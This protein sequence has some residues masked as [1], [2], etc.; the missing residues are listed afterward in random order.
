MS[1]L[2]KY[3][4]K[5]SYVSSLRS[6]KICSW[7]CKGFSTQPGV[8]NSALVDLSI[9]FFIVLLMIIY[10]FLT[11]DLI[12]LSSEILETDPKVLPPKKWV[13]F[14]ENGSEVMEAQEASTINPDKKLAADRIAKELD[15]SLKHESLSVV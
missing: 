13:I 11:Q 8:K 1:K 2:Y 5:I 12:H 3:N 7:V 15:D 6:S 14:M 10:I 4:K 9:Y